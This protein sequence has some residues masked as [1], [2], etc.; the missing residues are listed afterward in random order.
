MTFRS[1]PFLWIHLAG[2]VLFPITLE[3]TWLGLEIGK[4]LPF[5][6]L[7][8]VLIAAMGTLPV[9]WMQLARPFDIFSIAVVSLK[10]EQ[11]TVRQRQ[12]L[13]Q[14]KTTRHR[15][16]SAIAAGLMLFIL[17]LL[18]R[19]SPLAIGVASWFPQWRLLGLAI[20]A[21]AFLAANLFFQVPISVFNVLMSKESR[22][23]NSEPCSIEKI[24]LDFTVPG[25]K[26]NK[27]LPLVE[28]TQSQNS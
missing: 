14:F 7:E 25:F 10:P 20:A 8:F 11:L 22:L 27:I 3:C 23:L 17:W 6:L 19:L 12:I 4:P 9:L 13:T 24:P 2:I 15:W 16:A 5:S 18:F 28:P 21:V 1:E 26:V